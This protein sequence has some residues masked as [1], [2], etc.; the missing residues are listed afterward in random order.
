MAAPARVSP[1][2]IVVL[3]LSLG[4][5]ATGIKWG[6]WVASGADSYG[7]VSQAA[8]WRDGQ[9]VVSQPF[10][11]VDGWPTSVEGVTP[12]GYAPRVS[13]HRRADIVPTYSFG[14]PIVMAPFLAV[15]GPQAVYLVVPLLG[16]LTVWLTY[17]MGTRLAGRWVGLA[18]A[19]LFAASPAFLIDV[20]APTSD[21]AVT[22]WWTLALALLTFAKPSAAAGAGLASALAVA[23]RP[24]TAVLV[25]VFMVSLLHE[26][27]QEP[28][29]VAFKRL[30]LFAI[31]SLSGV[32]FV[33]A[34]N[35]HLYGSPFMSG[36]GRLADIYAIGNV[37]ANLHTYPLWLVQTQTPLVALALVGPVWW[38]SAGYPGT[39]LD[40]PGRTILFWAAFMLAAVAGYFFYKPWDDW[41]YLRFLLPA[42]PPLA[43]FTALGVAAAVSR[44]RRVHR[45]APRIAAVLIVVA[46]AAWTVRWSV[47][48]R[49]LEGWETERR[50]VLAGDY[51]RSSLPHQA[52]L[53]SMQHS[54]SARYYSGRVT[55]RYDLL[56]PDRLDRVLEG[57]RALGYHPYFLLEHWEEDEFRAHFPGNRLASLDWLPIAIIARDRVRIYDPA[58]IDAGLRD[59]QL[60]AIID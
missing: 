53:L 35:A 9:L 36:Y 59:R 56:P 16:A 41:V 24:N 4:I 33:A 46:A 22:A 3:G 13:E 58:Q 25:P 6:A 28:T 12:L 29:S 43:V 60:P 48:H 57:L 18:A 40:G 5:F 50:Y 47:A 1:A 21:V 15:G 55:V 31:T 51:I 2:A 8:L 10:A 19:A 27:W 45:A 37:A 52:V 39:R 11:E 49:L 7:Y 17:L 30:L 20:V 34:V 32:V 42:Y 54:G 26:A 23:T 14:L 44:L 38:R